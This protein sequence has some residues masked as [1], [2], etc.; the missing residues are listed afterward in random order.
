MEIDFEP[1]LLDK[2]G[3]LIRSIYDFIES[4]Q[5]K[6]I[7]EQ[8][9]CLYKWLKNEITIISTNNSFYHIKSK[10]DTYYLKKYKLCL[11]LLKDIVTNGSDYIYKSIVSD[12]VCSICTDNDNNETK[13]KI[14]NCRHIFHRTCLQEWFKTNSTCPLCRKYTPTLNTIKLNNRQIRIFEKLIRY[15]MSDELFDVYGDYLK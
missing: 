7:D 15:I 5:E 3:D 13:V 11:K 12:E 14:D 2:D 1:Y 9:K 6:N 10:D 8:Y 4:I